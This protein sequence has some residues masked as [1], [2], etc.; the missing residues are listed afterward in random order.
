MVEG[1]IWAWLALRAKLPVKSKEQVVDSIN[2]LLD[3]LKEERDYV[4]SDTW[5]IERDVRRYLRKGLGR[6][7]K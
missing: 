1:F 7:F 3:M 4:S 6:I 2:D 5:E